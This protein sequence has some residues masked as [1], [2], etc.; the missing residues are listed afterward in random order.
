MTNTDAA[1]RYIEELFRT[2][3]GG[4]DADHSLRVWRTALRIAGTEPS[5]DREIVALATLLHDADDRKLFRTENNANARAF[6]ESVGMPGE[7]TERI[8]EVINGVSFSQNGDRPPRTLEGQIVQDADRLDALG[9][10]GIARTFAYG[11]QHGRP[12]S[13]SIR[14]FYEK[15]LLLK[16]RMNTAEGRR[17]AEVRHARLERFLADWREETEEAGD[18]TV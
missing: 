18:R 11:G 14:H 9:A 12:M 4:H 8:C 13:E 3:A 1:I 16:D 5:C 7:R 2:D 6:L 15:L 17:L 10:V